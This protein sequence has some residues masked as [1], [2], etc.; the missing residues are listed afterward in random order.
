MAEVETSIIIKVGDFRR[1]NASFRS[2]IR[3]L[4]DEGMERN[5]P[6]FS[7]FLKKTVRK[8]WRY[9]GIEISTPEEE[10]LK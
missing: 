10:K 5:L 1:F 9:K 4:K 6:I 3:F 2:L 7:F 8:T